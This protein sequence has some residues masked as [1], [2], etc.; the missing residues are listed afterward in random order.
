MML[1]VKVAL[2]NLRKC[3]NKVMIRKKGGIGL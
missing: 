3:V 2:L 1:Y